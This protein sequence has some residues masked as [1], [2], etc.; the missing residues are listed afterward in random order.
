M[1]YRYTLPSLLILTILLVQCRPFLSLKNETERIRKEAQELYD[2]A[3]RLLPSSLH[4]AAG[5]GIMAVD[6]AYK[7]SLDPKAVRFVAHSTATMLAHEA[8]KT[9]V[10]R[11]T[12]KF[13]RIFGTNRSEAVCSMLL[14]TYC[15]PLLDDIIAA[16]I[17]RQLA[18]IDPSFTGD[19]MVPPLDT[20]IARRLAA[21]DLDNAV[22]VVKGFVSEGSAPDYAQAVGRR[23]VNTVTYAATRNWK[24]LGLTY[25]YRI[26]GNQLETQR[27]GVATTLPSR[28]TDSPDGGRRQQP[29]P[30]IDH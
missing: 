24:D 11:Q 15:Y 6:E 21:F 19:T 22:A 4:D 23:P 20:V 5:I 30:G 18:R 26:N 12:G 28:R 3:N 29:L 25:Q 7:A 1:R 10:L 13:D 8:V 16:A 14:N 2:D 17:D 27:R 9:I